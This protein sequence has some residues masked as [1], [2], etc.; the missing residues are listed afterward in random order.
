MRDENGIIVSSS[1][2]VA[3]EES[4]G[5]MPLRDKKATG[6]RLEPTVE[7]ERLRADKN[8]FPELYDAGMGFHEISRQIWQQGFKHYDKPFGYHGVETILSNSA[9]LG[10]PS[11][12]KL[13]VGTYR[14]LHAERA[15]EQN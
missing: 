13:G 2:T 12:G 15:G 10:L 14:V 6:Y 9:Y 3:K 4:S 11:W 8:D 7:V 1:L 5:R